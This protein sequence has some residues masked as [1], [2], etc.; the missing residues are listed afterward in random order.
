VRK[1]T[2]KEG[3][4]FAVPVD[5]Q[6]VVGRIAAVGR[7][8][9]ILIGYFFEPLRNEIPTLGSLSTLQPEDAFLIA[10]FT[11]AGLEKEGWPIIPSLAGWQ[12]E[13]WPIPLFGRTSIYVPGTGFATRYDRDNVSTLGTETRTSAAAA[14]QLPM[15]ILHGHK[16]LQYSLSKYFRE[17][18]RKVYLREPPLSTSWYQGLPAK[19]S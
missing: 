11:D 3:D 13:L 15:D 19:R 10:L 18:C 9:G 5:S 17:G 16:A 8:G 14:M 7:Q 4:W 12:R 1:K 2:F 6:Y